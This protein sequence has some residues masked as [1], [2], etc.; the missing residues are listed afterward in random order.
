MVLL[1]SGQKEDGVRE[2]VGEEDFVGDIEEVLDIVEVGVVDDDDDPEPVPAAAVPVAVGANDD[3]GGSVYC[4]VFYNSAGQGRKERATA[5]STQSHSQPNG[6]AHHDHIQC[7]QDHDEP[8]GHLAQ[9]PYRLFPRRRFIGLLVD[10]L[11]RRIVHSFQAPVGRPGFHP[12]NDVLPLSA[13]VRLSDATFERVSICPFGL[14]LFLPF[15]SFPDSRFF[16]PFTTCI[17]IYICNCSSKKKKRKKK[18]KFHY[19]TL[20]AYTTHTPSTSEPR[21]Q[22]PQSSAPPGAP[23]SKP[24]PPPHQVPPQTASSLDP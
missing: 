10:I 20:A 8:E 16:H 4:L 2:L 17:Y 21:P 1:A 15:G 24:P 5:I 14:G 19:P 12:S 7:Y 9:T 11:L 6:H 23:Q 22:N 3:S 13:L 18:K